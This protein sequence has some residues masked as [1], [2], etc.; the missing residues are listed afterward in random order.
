MNDP[1]FGCKNEDSSCGFNQLLGLNEE[2][3][4]GGEP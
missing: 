2:T 4:W 1:G 3:G